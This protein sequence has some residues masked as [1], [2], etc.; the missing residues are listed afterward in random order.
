MYYLVVD[1]HGNAATILRF[2][3]PSSAWGVVNCRPIYMGGWFVTDKSKRGMKV[4]ALPGAFV[5]FC[6][7]EAALPPDMVFRNAS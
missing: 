7:T 2:G 5:L 1:G 6:A 3:L 4:N